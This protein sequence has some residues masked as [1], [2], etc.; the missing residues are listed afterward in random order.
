MY[1]Q[2][3]LFVLFWSNGISFLFW[4]P[5]IAYRGSFGQDC[6]HSLC[7]MTKTSPVVQRSCSPLDRSLSLLFFIKTTGKDTVAEA[8]F[9]SYLVSCETLWLH[10]KMF[11]SL[12]FN[13]SDPVICH[14]DAD[15]GGGKREYGD[16]K[17]EFSKWVSMCSPA[18]IPRWSGLARVG[19]P[20]CYHNI[21]QVPPELSQTT[22]IYAQRKVIPPK[23]PGNLCHIQEILCVSFMGCS[24][25]YL[26]Q[27]SWREEFMPPLRNL[28]V[29]YRIT[30]A[31]AVFW[32]AS[33]V[34]H[35]HPD[36]QLVSQ[37]QYWE[38]GKVYKALWRLKAPQ[39]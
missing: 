17:T 8:C 34:L 26:P 7:L 14:K 19:R 21:F 30:K 2:R 4:V 38:L 29:S 32:L 23:S 24:Q 3:E 5:G 18:V 28:I 1:I 15:G 12:S 9:K 33:Q 13:T 35:Q 31:T 25:A 6:G 10:L 36:T 37:K 22:E 20:V 27:G 11:G 39:Y 16:L